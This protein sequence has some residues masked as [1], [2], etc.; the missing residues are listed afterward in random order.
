MFHSILKFYP[1][2]KEEIIGRGSDGDEKGPDR[3]GPSLFFKPL[4]AV[5]DQ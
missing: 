3:S 2:M 1:D 5:P 4:T